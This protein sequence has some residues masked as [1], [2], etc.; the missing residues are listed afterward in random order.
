V[1]FA[2][3]TDTAPT[4]GCVLGRIARPLIEEALSGEPDPALQRKLRETLTTS[5]GEPSPKS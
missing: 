3:T 4:D 1:S 5:E 2:S